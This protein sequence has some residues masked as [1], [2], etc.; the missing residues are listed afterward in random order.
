MNIIQAISYIFGVKEKEVE[1]ILDLLEKKTY[2][3]KTYLDF[4]R[5]TIEEI[6]KKYTG[7]KKWAALTVL[8]A[9][10]ASAKAKEIARPEDA[11][12]IIKT[13]II[14]PAVEELKENGA[15]VNVDKFKEIYGIKLEE[16]EKAIEKVNEIG[17]KYDTLERSLS[18]LKEEDDMTKMVAI[19]KAIY[20]TRIIVENT[21]KQQA[22]T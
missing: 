8:N 5:E 22:T 18:A 12:L 3:D 20:I 4:Q 21:N 2:K 10:L 16:L 1:E 7:N 17:N 13:I 11:D 6:L 15:T 19:M 9:Y 14:L